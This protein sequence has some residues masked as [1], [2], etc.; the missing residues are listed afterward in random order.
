[1]SDISYSVIKIIQTYVITRGSRCLDVSY[2]V[3]EIIQTYVGKRG[4]RSQM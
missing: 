2:S 1:M 3:I 4:S